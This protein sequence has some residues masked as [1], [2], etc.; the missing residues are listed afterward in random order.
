MFNSSM[1]LF[2]LS[3]LLI[4]HQSSSLML[5]CF[6][7]ISTD[8]VQLFIFMSALYFGLQMHFNVIILFPFCWPSVKINLY[9]ILHGLIYLPFE[10]S[11]NW[12][13]PMSVIYR[14][15]GISGPRTGAACPVA[16]WLKSPRSLAMFTKSVSRDRNS[17]DWCSQTGT[18]VRPWQCLPRISFQ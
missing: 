6:P 16:L 10:S 2:G 17:I 1:L 11:S 5:C 13:L 14:V 8:S 3:P 9:Q 4:G 7:S 18:T 12:I 15:S